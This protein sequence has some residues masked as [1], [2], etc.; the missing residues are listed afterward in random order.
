MLS[1][2][3]RGLSS[4]SFLRFFASATKDLTDRV[5]DVIEKRIRPALKMDGGDVIVESVKDGVVE[6][7]L[8]GHCS[9]CPARNETLRY[10]IL[11]TLQEEIPEIKVVREM[12]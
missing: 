10:G 1:Q 9:G 12:K 5:N 7:T 11:S 2:I 8:L 3:A 4:P 6:C